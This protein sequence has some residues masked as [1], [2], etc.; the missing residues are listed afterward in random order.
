MIGLEGIKKAGSTDR[1]AIRDAVE[2]I[3]YDGFL[4]LY[5][6]TPTDHQGSP[7][8]TMPEMMVRNGEFVPYAK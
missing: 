7:R 1:A 4:G 5:E 6:V 2:K 8:D 3:K